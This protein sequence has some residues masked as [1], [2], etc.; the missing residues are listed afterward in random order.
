[1]ELTDELYGQVL[2][3]VE[4]EMNE[5]ER[6]SF[7]AL[8]LKNVELQDEVELY[9]EIRSLSGSIDQKICAVDKDTNENEVFKMIKQAR[10]TWEK[11]EGGNLVQQ[12]N[13][14]DEEE[15]QLDNEEGFYA[16]EIP[17]KPVATE[18]RNVRAIEEKEGNV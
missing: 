6:R 7:E 11:S 13:I 4:N 5:Q 12:V 2:R 18:Q 15:Q 14:S 1:M 3:Y 16:R 8:L 10:E 9:T 17:R